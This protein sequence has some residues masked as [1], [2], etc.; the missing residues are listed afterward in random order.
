[1]KIAAYIAGDKNIIKSSIV[2]FT[3]LEK[4]EPQLCKYIF[5]DEVDLEVEDKKDLENLGV[6]IIRFEKD[7]I[8]TNSITWPKESFLNFKAPEILY[9][10]GYDYA[11][12]LDYDIL[13]NGKLDID[14]QL[15]TKNIFSLNS[16]NYETLKDM[17]LGDYEYFEKEF[18]VK[19]WFRKAPLFGN[20][21]INLQKYRDFGFWEKYKNSFKEILTNTPSKG[22]DLI[23][24]DMGLF[25]AVMEKYS[26]EYDVNHDRYNSCASLRHLKKLDELDLNPR[27]IHYPGPKKPWKPLGVKI[28]TNPYYTFLR[29]KWISFVMEETNFNWNLKR[30]KKEKNKI[31]SKIIK[32]KAYRKYLEIYIKRG[33]K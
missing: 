14:E 27:V 29:E 5:L 17:I 8:F 1:M 11:I 33:S 4:F 20:V 19:N 10:L 22:G 28:I 9:D 15:P 16:H 21:Y 26:L 7:E 31:S 30:E 32:S 23:F 12:K 3:S 25:A 24:A 2:V 18:N 13:I 6:S